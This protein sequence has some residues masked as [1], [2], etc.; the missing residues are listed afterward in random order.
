MV[1][2]ASPD[3]PVSASRC[4]T[5]GSRCV[6]VLVGNVL[7][8]AT[9]PSTPIARPAVSN[10]AIHFFRDLVLIVSKITAPITAP[11]RTPRTVLRFSA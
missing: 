2:D 11:T 10:G 5:A 9:A 4:T 3:G 1:R 6:S 8:Q 7:T